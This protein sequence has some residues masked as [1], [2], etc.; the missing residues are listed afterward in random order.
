MVEILYFMKLVL[1]SLKPYKY[2]SKVRDWDVS[3]AHYTCF[4]RWSMYCRRLSS[5]LS[6]ADTSEVRLAS[7]RACLSRTTCVTTE[8]SARDNSQLCQVYW[9]TCLLQHRRY[10]ENQHKMN[11]KQDY[12]KIIQNTVW[13]KVCGHPCFRFAVSRFQL[14]PL[15][16]ITGILHA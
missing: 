11:T 13:P 3:T 12:A 2:M 6:W 1:W 14:G 10:K 8:T 4:S 5:S 7:R 15:V 16:P 9:Q